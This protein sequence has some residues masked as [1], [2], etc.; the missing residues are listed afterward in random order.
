MS[1]KVEF[2]SLQ[3]LLPWVGKEVVV[4]DW[5][6]ITQERINQFAQATDDFQWIHIDAERAKQ[7]PFGATIAHGFLTL[8]MIAGFTDRT[9]GVKAKM[10]IKYGLNK[11]RFV[12]PVPVNSRLRARYT[13][14]E[15]NEVAG[16]SQS[17]W[18]VTIEREGSDKPACIAE[19]VRNDYF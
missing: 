3:D 5:I 18:Q 4:S 10:S 19:T 9:M 15:I 17:V 1:A 2:S 7:G 6:T 12:S 16:G 8:S 11:V 14:K 13:L